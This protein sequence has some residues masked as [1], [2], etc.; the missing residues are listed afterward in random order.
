MLEWF[1]GFLRKWLGLQKINKIDKW[2]KLKVIICFSII[3][4]INL[5]FNIL[6]DL[7]PQTQLPCFQGQIHFQAVGFQLYNFFG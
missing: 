6:D 2:V 3:Q 4:T 5:F 1:H 7:K